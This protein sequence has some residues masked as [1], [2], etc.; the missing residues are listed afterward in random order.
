MCS[1]PALRI[2][3][4]SSAKENLDNFRGYHIEYRGE[5]E[6]KGKGRMQTYFLTGRDGFYKALPDPELFEE[7]L[8][9]TTKANGYSHYQRLQCET[10]EVGDEPLFHGRLSASE[11]SV[12]MA[13][14]V[15]RNE[16]VHT[17]PCRTG[18]MN[19]SAIVKAGIK[20]IMR[21]HTEEV[22]DDIAIIISDID[23]DISSHGT[24]LQAADSGIDNIQM[25][26]KLNIT[27]KEDELSTGKIT[28]D[29]TLLPSDQHKPHLELFNTNGN[30]AN[31]FSG[32][33]GSTDNVLD[34]IKLA[35]ESN[36]VSVSKL[37]SLRDRNSHSDTAKVGTLSQSEP[38]KLKDKQNPVKEGHTTTDTETTESGPL[39]NPLEYL[40]RSQKITDPNNVSPRGKQDSPSST[41]H[42]EITPNIFP[43]NLKHISDKLKHI[44]SDGS[45]GSMLQYGQPKMENT[46]HRNSPVSSRSPSP[47]LNTG[48]IRE[49]VNS[50]IL[51]ATD[52]TPL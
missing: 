19:E 31:H 25:E 1:L 17:R 5:I 4:S 2:H 13:N 22:P 48:L 40:F 3:M 11:Q 15:E 50:R 18:A 52:T 36:Y 7:T 29:A 33:T 47:K 10:E 45:S 39:H 49:Q 44:Y 24:Q 42:L 6:V 21:Q 8:S 30:S 43:I 20:Q 28:Q 26:G 37:R 9:R 51:K 46:E 32:S 16:V 12:D 23:E 14:F 27:D 38:S 41:R 35:T 34:L